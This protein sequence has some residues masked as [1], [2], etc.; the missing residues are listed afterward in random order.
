MFGS[1]V[2]HFITLLKPTAKATGKHAL[3]VGTTFVHDVIDGKPI[4]KA[5]MT[6]KKS[7][8]RKNNKN[9]RR[10][11]Q[12]TILKNKGKGKQDVFA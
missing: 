1:F 10:V 11:E 6:G 5:T 8:K 9:R 4:A 3:R 7:V 12:S 2:W